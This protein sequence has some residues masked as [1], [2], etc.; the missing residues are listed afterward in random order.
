MLGYVLCFNIPVDP[1]IIVYAREKSVTILT[2]NIIYH[3]VDD[4]KRLLSDRLSPTVIYN[5]TGEAEILQ[6]FSINI[7][8]NQHKPVAGCKVK[9]GVIVRNS[10][11]RVVR[12]GN[13]IFEGQLSSLKNVKKDVSIMK[14]ENE[15]GIGFDGWGEFEV[16][17]LV[18]CYEVRLEP[19]TL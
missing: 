9:T 19:R 11:V 8:K 5:V 3:L 4:V 13:N 18:Q 12:D 16:G 10:K 7:K 6:V 2:H 1:E 14:K 17:D 15:C